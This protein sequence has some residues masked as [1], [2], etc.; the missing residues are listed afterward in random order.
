M[1]LW[2]HVMRWIAP[3]RRRFSPRVEAA[4]LSLRKDRKDLFRKVQLAVGKLRAAGIAVVAEEYDYTTST[5]HNYQALPRA[6]RGDF[7]SRYTEIRAGLDIAYH[8]VY[9]AERQ[10]LQDVLVDAVVGDQQP[11]QRVPW[12]IFSAGPMGAG[13]SYSVKWMAEKGI[14]PLSHVVQVDPDIFKRAL[15]EWPGYVAAN[16]RTAGSLTHRE[17]GYLVEIAME[18][19]MRE[20][21]HIWVDGSLRNATWYEEVFRNIRKRHPD[22]QIAI[23]YIV[24]PKETIFKRCAARSLATGR[25]V[26]EQ[27]ILDSIERVPRSVSLLQKHADFLVVIFNGEGEEPQL[28][29]HCDGELCDTKSEWSKI[30][31]RFRQRE[32]RNVSSNC[33]RPWAGL[34]CR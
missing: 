25:H 3:F 21:Q 15:P 6:L 27:E 17:S 30:T 32:R 11:A 23:F 29:H 2:P 7:N 10:R 5:A 20:Q 18:A 34:R 13:K 24:A 19:A 22:Y 14:L 16:P 31:Q 12:I 28:Q 33:S 4:R 26:P 8:G 9:S 1:R